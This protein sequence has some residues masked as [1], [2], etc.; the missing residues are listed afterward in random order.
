MVSSEYVAARSFGVP[1]DE[2]RTSEVV[3]VEGSLHALRQDTTVPCLGEGSVEP[4]GGPWPPSGGDA[5]AFVCS[6]CGRKL[7]ANVPEPVDRL[8]EKHNDV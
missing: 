7:V 2:L 4:T 8:V 5:L 1:A 3:S 6:R